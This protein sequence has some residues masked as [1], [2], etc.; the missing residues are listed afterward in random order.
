[1]IGLLRIS[2]PSPYFSGLFNSVTISNF[3]TL[4]NFLV[5]LVLL[6]LFFI[7]P[8]SGLPSSSSLFPQELT[9][10]IGRGCQRGRNVRHHRHL[11]SRF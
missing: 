10:I 2:I 11:H 6:Y 1:M 4:F 7:P 5:I 8:V 9:T 3:E